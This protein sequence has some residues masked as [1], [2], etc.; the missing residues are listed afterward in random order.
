MIDDAFDRGTHAYKELVKALKKAKK[1]DPDNK[2]KYDQAIA[3]ANDAIDFGTTVAMAADVL[4]NASKPKKAKPKEAKEKEAEPKTE[5]VEA[6][7]PEAEPAPEESIN[8]DD[9]FGLFL[10]ELL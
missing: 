4:K 1:A 2:E 10:K 9:L 5:V 6:A 7:K 3:F 8:V